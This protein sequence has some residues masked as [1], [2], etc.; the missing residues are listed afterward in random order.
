MATLKYGSLYINAIAFDVPTVLLH[1]KA[2]KKI[3]EAWAGV[4]ASQF[5]FYTGHIK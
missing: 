4:V 5:C 3:L 2:S 1:R